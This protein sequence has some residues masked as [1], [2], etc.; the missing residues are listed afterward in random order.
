[1]RE[2]EKERSKATMEK[3]KN[4]FEIYEKRQNNF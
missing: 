2:R 1:M 4:E 3:L